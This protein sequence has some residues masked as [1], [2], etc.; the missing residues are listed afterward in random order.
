MNERTPVVRIRAMRLLSCLAFAVALAACGSSESGSASGSPD[1]GTSDTGAEDTGAEDTGATDSGSDADADAGDDATEDT[2]AEDTG[3]EDASEDAV[4]PE[5][6]TDADCDDGVAC[7][8]D[9]CAPDTETCT[10]T[11][12][13]AAC[14]DGAFCNG[15]EVC[16]AT[17]G[18]VDGDAP[19]CDDG[20]ACTV[21]TCDEDAD[22]CANAPDDAAC[23]DG[24]YCDGVEVCD[25]TLGCVSGDPVV[26]DDGFDCTIDVCDEAG[27]TCRTLSDDAACDD[28][29]FCNGAEVCDADAGCVAGEAPTCED[30]F[31]CTTGSCD[32]ELDRCV[33]DLDHDACADTSFCN[34]LELCDPTRGC[35][36]GPPVN[37][38][39]GDACTDDLC[40]EDAGRCLWTIVD[41]DGDGV[42]DEACGGSDCDDDRP[43]TYPGADEL[44]DAAD[45]DCDGLED[46]GVLNTC[47]TCDPD[48]NEVAIGESAVDFAMGDALHLRWSDDDGG[49][50]VGDPDDAPSF[51]WLPNTAE[52]TMSRWDARRQVELARYRVGLPVGECPGTCCWTNGCNM[53]SRVSV[54]WRGDAYIASRGFAMQGT[55]TRVFADADDCADGNGNGAIDTAFDATALDWDADECIDW[56]AP[57]GPVNAVLRAMAIDRG[58]AARP[59][60]YV[61][62]GGYNTQMFYKLDPRTGETLATVDVSPINPYGAVVTDDGRLWYGGLSNAAIGWF[63][64]TAD[65]PTATRLPFPAMRGGCTQAYGLTADSDGR[66]W[67]TGWGCQDVL[68]YDPA[69]DAWTRASGF[70]TLVGRGIAVTDDGDVWFGLGGD[71]QASLARFP[72]SAFVPDGSIPA[73]AIDTISIPAGHQGPSGVGIDRDGFIWLG[74]HVTS[75]LVRIDPDS[76]RTV[77]M[78]GPNRVYTYSDFTGSVRRSVLQ[79]GFYERTVDSACDAPT[80]TTLDVDAAVPDGARLAIYVRSADDTEGIAADAH[81]LAFEAGDD[82]TVDLATLLGADTTG[83][84][85]AITVQ[86]E[87]ADGESSPVVHGLRARWTCA[88]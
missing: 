57:V 12:D 8:V 61:W 11:A 27:Q 5:C 71:S 82:A 74:H 67:T 2:G 24:V 79:I 18:C 37:C 28:G 33:L 46:E 68:G 50:V 16:D 38:D 56:T 17:L 52:S 80:W 30:A 20:L 53:P 25:T 19:A 70:G 45:Q 78:G 58:D 6:T 36:A 64:T 31:D 23:D 4:A 86:V 39:D 42:A 40:D 44:C 62:V 76:L 66:I 13:D 41:A 1:T 87:T 22:A 47:G 14:D 59:E 49:L 77:S 32:A 21:D 69:T 7:T 43:T 73:G 51:L 75:Q 81:V 3:G 48:C 72:A 85:L 63:D 54:D 26:C 88:D 15:A 34:G 60:G 9:T 84:L 83:R 55:V 65:A 10:R 29:T 35:V